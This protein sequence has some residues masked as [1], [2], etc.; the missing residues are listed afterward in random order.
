[1]KK[2]LIPFIRDERTFGKIWF[3]GSFWPNPVSWVQ[4]Q[5][6]SGRSMVDTCF[7]TTLLP[8]LTCTS[9]TSKWHVTP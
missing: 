5:Y 1:M 9:D 2:I 7:S 4:L 3:Y 6:I 8:V